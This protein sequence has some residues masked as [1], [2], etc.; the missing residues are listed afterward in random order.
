MANRERGEFQLQAG[1]RAY[2]MRLTTNACAELED[3]N[4]KQTLEQVITDINT[5]SIKAIRV[6]LWAA[7]RDRHPEI[8]T[9]DPAC[10]NAIGNIVDAA[11]GI[12]GVL[13]QIKAFMTMNADAGGRVNPPGAANL[14]GIG[15]ASTLTSSR[16]A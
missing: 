15:A 10:L 3:F 12:S 9:D 11:G 7:L 8:A 5:G 14:H 6:L 13:A 16:S 2:T 4:A 1:E